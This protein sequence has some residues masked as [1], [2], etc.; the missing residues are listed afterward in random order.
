MSIPSLVPIPPVTRES[1][2]SSL[3]RTKNEDISVANP[4][5]NE[6]DGFFEELAKAK[7][8]FQQIVFGINT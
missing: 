3:T 8:A 1:N 2:I 6:L 7:A 5:K 4:I